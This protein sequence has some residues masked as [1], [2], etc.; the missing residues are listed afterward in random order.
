MI[1]TKPCSLAMVLMLNVFGVARA[2]PFFKAYEGELLPEQ[3]GWTRTF[4]DETGP[5]KGPGGQ[6]SL[7]DGTF[8]LDTTASI[9][10]YDFYRLHR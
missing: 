1:R 3:D 9:G 8:R 10:I 7:Q 2:A 6:R 5:F 4:G